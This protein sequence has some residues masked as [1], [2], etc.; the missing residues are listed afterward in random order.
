MRRGNYLNRGQQL[1]LIA[2]INKEEVY[3]SLMS[4]DDQK[5]PGYDDFNALL[6]KRAWSIIGEEVTNIVLQY[7]EDSELYKAINFTITLIPKVQNPSKIS[8]FRSISYCTMLYKLISKVLTRR[9]QEVMDSLV[10]QSQSAFVPSRLITDNIILSHEFVKGYG[11][12]GITPRCMLKIDM[13]KAYDSVEW[14][15][16]E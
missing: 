13:G 7:F 16:I 5:A 4:I 8:E 15:Y 9:M 11:Q 3:Q 2:P 1:S 10:D 14:Q 6:F 12:K